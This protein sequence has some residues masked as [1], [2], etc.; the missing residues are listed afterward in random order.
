MTRFDRIERRMPALFDEL[1]V[2][3]P[4]DYLDEILSVTAAT[5]QRPAWTFLQRWL[6]MS[7]LNYTAT[8]G[9]SR[10][11]QLL[12]VL[13]FLI[14][15]MLGV[16]TLLGGSRPDVE[17]LNLFEPGRSGLVAFE[18]NGD[19][20][21]GDPATGVVSGLVAGPEVDRMPAWSLDGRR[22]AFIRLVDVGQGALYV[23]DGQDAA[24]ALVRAEPFAL[25]T[26][27]AWSPDG[28]SVLV[29]WMRG[30]RPVVSLVDVRTGTT[31]DIRHEQSVTAASFRPPEGHEILFVGG[32]PG[33]SGGQ[34]IFAYDRA[35]ATIRTI[36]EQKPG[37][38]IQ[39]DPTWSPD[40]SRLAY[41]ISVPRGPARAFTVAA[42]GGEPRPVNAPGDTASESGPVWAHD[43]THLALIRWYEKGA[44]IAVVDPS[45]GGRG[46]ETPIPEMGS[47]GSRRPPRDLVAS[48]LWAPDDA[49][50]LIR[51]LL[52]SGVPARQVLIDPWAGSSVPLSWVSTSDPAWQRL[53]P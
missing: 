18:A 31:T 34:G 48:L 46:V 16:A 6:P 40:G 42:E 20:Q 44:V 41:A 21:G 7:D 39:G 2:G 23:M 4:T 51:P 24:P 5:S 38:I 27:L 45:E 43:G 37:T 47:T 8:F 17:R 15:C 14:L 26:G 22:L 28:Q 29:S 12:L 3:P 9:P 30:T 11:L 35:T 19:I 10:G 32:G 52:T 33:S 49:R 25:V 53:E 1:A 36:V 13:A 50:L